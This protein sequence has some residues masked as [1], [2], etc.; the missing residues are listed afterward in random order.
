MI[1]RRLKL[2]GIAAMAVAALTACTNV[3]GAAV[4]VGDER[5]PEA[6]VDGYVDE[7]A[8][9]Q[10]ESAEIDLAG[11]DYTVDR[12]FVVEYVVLA[13]LGRAMELEKPAEAD[14]T[15]QG[16][17]YEGN[18]YRD[19]LSREAE[20]RELSQAEVDAMNNAVAG[21]QQLISKIVDQWVNTAGLTDDEIEQ[22]Y[23]AAQADQAVVSEVVRQ[24]TE[25]QAGLADDLT[26]Y[27]EEYDISA[28]P[29]YGDVSIT[30]LPGVWE[31]EIPQK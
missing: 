19:A 27:V 17:Y 12:E 29:R 22:F 8:V 28:S 20:P 4:F 6:T 21:D 25:S 9:L 24:W 26:E 16:L 5:I 13:E 31:V 30:L 18:A 23:T 1:V 2:A 10:T 3:Q 14:E 15:L 11:Y 7:L